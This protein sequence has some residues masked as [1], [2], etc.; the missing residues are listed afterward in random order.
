MN[1]ETE[2]KL[3]LSMEILP[4]IKDKSIECV[5]RHILFS[6]NNNIDWNEALDIV[7]EYMPELKL[8]CMKGESKNENQNQKRISKSKFNFWK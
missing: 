2:I 7:C 1:K 3:L 5:L 4:N 6:D 8:F